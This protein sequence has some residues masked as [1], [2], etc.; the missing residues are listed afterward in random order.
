MTADHPLRLSV[1]VPARNE[2]HE[3][4]TTLS[5]LSRSFGLSSDDEIIVV[6]GQSTDGSDCIAA[7]HAEIRHLQS[8]PG[9][10]RQMNTGAAAAT[11][12]LL[13]FCHADTH[14]CDGSA[15]DLKQLFRR[16]RN[17]VAVAFHFAL[18]DERRISFL[19]IIW[20]VNLR[21]TILGLPYGDQCFVVR[22]SVFEQIGGYRC[23]ERCEDLDFWLRVRRV[24]RTA[25]LPWPAYTSARRWQRDG[26]WATTFD[27]LIALL[28]YLLGKKQ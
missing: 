19:P 4:P 16:R 7:S 12:D 1:V 11:G 25:I 8:E 18:S 13:L 26:I 20:G 2:A 22:R 14:P 17:L 5:K 27:N 23:L 15:P 24:G 21:S 10:A 3:L 9:R 28:R 6:D